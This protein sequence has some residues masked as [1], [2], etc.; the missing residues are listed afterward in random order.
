MQH[1]KSWKPG[2]FFVKD[3][4]GPVC[5]LTVNMEGPE[6]ADHN[7][8]MRKTGSRITLSDIRSHSKTDAPL[9][10]LTSYT[11]P[12]TKILDP[13]CDILL[14]GDSLGMV[15][16]GMENTVGVTLDMMVNHGKAVV[17][18]AEHAFVVVDMPYGSYGPDLD[19]SFSNACRL[20][21][22]T[23]CD[24]LKLEVNKSLAPVIEHLVKNG[25]PVQAH[26]GLCPQN[27]EKE[28]G[29]RIKGK[30]EDNILGLIDDAKACEQ[31]GAFSVLIEGTKEEATRRIVEAVSVPTVGIG[32]SWCC[33]GQI[34]VVDDMI[35]MT[36]G[37]T[38]KFVKQYGQI[39][40]VI[41]DAVRR[42]ADEV[43]K[44]SFPDKDYVY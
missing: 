17:R 15:V 40:D 24:A 21:D 38:A 8:I 9:V 31:A 44:H 10:C 35:G 42:Y 13:H 32:A 3:R 29:Y 11:A 41:E 1:V 7:G 12:M 25:I 4:F 28:G 43:R 19:M 5:F 22:E 39:A 34:L 18:A 6:M 30:T 27:V 23:G 2:A 36:R 26:I 33:D 37:H 20:F 14:V 16:Y